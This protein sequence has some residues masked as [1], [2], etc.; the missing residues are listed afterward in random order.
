M[1]QVNDDGG[2]DELDP[3]E[4]EPLLAQVAEALRT[5]RSDRIIIRTAP[6]DSATA[7]TVVAMSS[8]PVAAALGVEDGDDRVDLWLELER[9]VP[10]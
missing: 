1:V 9:P 2:V 7:V 6:R 8:D 3:A 4:L 10:A 5:L